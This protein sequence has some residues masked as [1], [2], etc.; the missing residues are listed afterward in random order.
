MIQAPV[1]HILT[2]YSLCSRTEAQRVCQGRTIC[3]STLLQLCPAWTSGHPENE[4][5]SGRVQPSDPQ[6][7]FLQF[8]YI[9][10]HNNYHNVI[11]NSFMRMRRVWLEATYANCFVNLD[12]SDGRDFKTFRAEVFKNKVGVQWC[13]GPSKTHR[14]WRRSML[15][16]E[17]HSWLVLSHWSGLGVHSVIF[18]LLSIEGL[19]Q[20][21]GF[22][23]HNSRVL[24]EN[25]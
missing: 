22:N 20:W 10:G 21:Q 3:M 25:G 17:L 1:E 6:L 7:K 16:S 24:T 14:R 11:I 5:A 4:T 9:V 18:F 12:Q 13:R 15:L 8:S 2:L 19:C 23:T